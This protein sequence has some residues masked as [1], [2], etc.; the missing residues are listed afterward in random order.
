MI[1]IYGL[2]AVAALAIVGITEVLI[3]R[4]KLLM[5]KQ[6]LEEMDKLD[7]ETTGIKKR[8]EE[9]NED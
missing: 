7:R 3:T 6:F 2:V 5:K 9:K 8:P 1:N 4:Q